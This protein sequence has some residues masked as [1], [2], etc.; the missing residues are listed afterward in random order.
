MNKGTR[1]GANKLTEAD[2]RNIRARWLP[3]INTA[4]LALRYNVCRQTIYAIGTG[5]TWGWLDD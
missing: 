2:V 5:Q 4:E 1:N 3:Y